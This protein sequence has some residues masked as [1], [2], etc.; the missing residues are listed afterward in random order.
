ML[1]KIVLDLCGG[2][3]SWSKPYKNAGYK[4]WIID[5]KS[6]QDNALLMD[7][8]NF[9]HTVTL[10]PWL[11]IEGILAAPPCTEFS[12]SGARWW[13]DKDPELLKEAIE[14]VQACL[15]IV[16]YFSPHW[17]CL[18]NPVGRLPKF[19]GPWQ[20]TFQ[21]CDNG[22]PYTKRTCLWGDFVMPEKSPVEPT[23]GS[24][25]WRLP[26][27]PNRAKLRSITPL[28]FAKAFFEANP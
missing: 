28:G 2:T 26:P 17:W 8:R 25:L 19:I 22:D 4:V 5:P 21:P 6:D 13:K 7:V 27:G 23:E 9:Q 14:I 16:K 20:H 11:H 3:G 10:T 1:P 12:G 15:D 24:K 18:E